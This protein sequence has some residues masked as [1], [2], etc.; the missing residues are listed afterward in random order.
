[1]DL[2]SLQQSNSRD[3]KYDLQNFLIIVF[4]CPAFNKNHKAL[5]HNTTKQ[6]SMAI[7][8]NKIVRNYPKEAGIRV[9]R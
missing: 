9:S 2:N 6:K 7:Q 1:M 4:K 8:R 3:G 5:K